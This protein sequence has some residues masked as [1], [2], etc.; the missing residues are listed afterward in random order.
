MAKVTLNLSEVLALMDPPASAL[1]SVDSLRRYIKATLESNASHRAPG[2]PM[3]AFHPCY[4]DSDY[5]K[6]KAAILQVI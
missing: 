6:I 3:V 2:R 5:R 1:Q 4:S